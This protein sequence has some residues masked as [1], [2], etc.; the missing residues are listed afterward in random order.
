MQKNPGKLISAL[1]SLQ[2]KAHTIQKEIAAEIFEGRAANGLVVLKISGKGEF[3]SAFIDP[4][5]LTE[6]SDTISALIVSA[7]NHASQQK[8]AIAKTKLASISA[9]MLPFGMRIPEL[10]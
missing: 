3:I 4:S 5:L 10:S 9:G 6:D 2:Q 7:G 1:A 8:D